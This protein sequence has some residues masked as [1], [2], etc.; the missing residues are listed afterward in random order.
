MSYLDPEFFARD[1]LEVARDLIGTELIVGRCEG[2][3]VETEAYTTDAASHFV[4]RRHQTAGFRE[5]YAHVYV[6]LIYGMHFCLNF[7][8]ERDGYGAVIIRAIEPT[9]GLRLMSQRRGTSEIKQ[10]CSGPGR[11][12]QAFGI[13]MSFNHLPIGRRL[14]LRPAAGPEPVV[15]RSRRI[16][17]T[18]AVELDW[19]F[20]EAGNAFVSGKRSEK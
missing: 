3:I 15:A 17:I 14:K 8:T 13:D 1:T 11:L 20:Y 6:F 18:R 10:L 12:C 16:G 19:R 7:T 5:T 9:R 2:K 4:M